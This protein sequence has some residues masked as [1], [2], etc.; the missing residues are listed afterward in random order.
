MRFVVSRTSGWSN[1]PCPYATL[2]NIEGAGRLAGRLE[3]LW[4]IEINSLEELIEFIDKYGYKSNG[5]VIHT[6]NHNPA[7]KEIEIYDDYRE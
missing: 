7:Y 2:R 6:C 1:A 4:T 5:V 3:A